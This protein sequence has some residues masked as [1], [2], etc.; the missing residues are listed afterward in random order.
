MAK[1]GLARPDLAGVSK[2]HWK[3]LRE[4]QVWSNS[5]ALRIVYVL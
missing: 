1:Q 5:K 2:N 3:A 4:D